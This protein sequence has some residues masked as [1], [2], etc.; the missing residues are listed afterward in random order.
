MVAPKDYSPL[1]SKQ[2][3]GGYVVKRVNILYGHFAVSD[4][5]EQRI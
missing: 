3:L 2:L 4:R 5:I 1:A